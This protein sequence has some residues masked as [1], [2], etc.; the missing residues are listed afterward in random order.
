MN[1]NSVIS[2]CSLY[3]CL[4]EIRDHQGTITVGL[5]LKSR[6]ENNMLCALSAL[7]LG[8]M[9]SSAMSLAQSQLTAFVGSRIKKLVCKDSS[10]TEPLA[11]CDGSTSDV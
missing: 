1:L 7:I 3:T 6:T 8:H 11:L 10:S 2:S 4:H 5:H 9:F